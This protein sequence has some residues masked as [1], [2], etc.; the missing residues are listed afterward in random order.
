MGWLKSRTL[1][2]PELIWGIAG[3]V[4][5]LLILAQSLISGGFQYE[6][7]DLKKPIIILVAMMV[8]AGMVH[9][10]VIFALKEI[11]ISK[12]LWVWIILC[13]LL[14][15]LSMFQSTPMLEDD[16]YRY[17]WDGGVLANGFNPYRYSPDTI[18]EAKPSQI[19]DTLRELARQ[20][21]SDL[22][23]INY[24]WLRTIYPPLTQFGFA[25]AHLISPWDII[26]WRLVLLIFDVITLCLLFVLLRHL[27]LPMIGLVIYWW[28]PLLVKEIYNSGHMEVMLFPFILGAMI[29]SM[30]G[31]YLWASCAIGLAVGIKFWPAILLPLLLRPILGQ[32]KR[33][34]APLLCFAG[35]SIAAFLP[36]Y[37]T[38]LGPDSGFTAY[39]RYWE[40]NDALFMV[41]LWTVQFLSN[42]FSFHMVFP[43][44]MTRVIVASL[45]LVFTL[46][47]LGRKYNPETMPSRA[48]FLVAALFI[49]SPTQ[50]PWYYLW[51][52]PLLAI[53]IQYAL[54]FLT[55]LLPL[56]YMRF[57]LDIRGMA[58]IHDKGVVWLEFMPVWY[59]FAKAFIR[60]FGRRFSPVPSIKV[61]P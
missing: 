14:F 29:F 37:L 32:P 39:G 6:I 45:L 31:R 23:R 60:A 3:L 24:P 42:F 7:S 8:G 38:G 55:A 43:Q 52:L 18:H 13:G 46:S 53:R 19:P 11:P 17:L 36:F 15:R 28:N 47:V 10:F 48:L 41:I 56:Y 12:G 61:D 22:E 35:L 50:F 33:C 27:N 2:R 58:P 20:Y 30:T 44:T 49:L 4:M 9:L 40:M 26:G 25:L 34:I 51:I 21:G 59:L 1:K 5:A 57:Y 54:L 16:H